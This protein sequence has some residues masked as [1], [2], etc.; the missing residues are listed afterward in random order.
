MV[1]SSPSGGAKAAEMDSSTDPKVSR[2]TAAVFVYVADTN[3]HRIQKFNAAGDWLNTWGTGSAGGGNDQFSY[4]TGIAVDSSGFIY[5]ADKSNHRIQKFNAAGDWLNTWGTGSAGGGNDQF[6][7]P[8]GIAVDSSG[9]IY[10]A[11]KSNHRIQKFDAAGGWVDT[12]GG[13]RLTGERIQETVTGSF[14]F[15]MVSRW[16]A[17][18]IF[19]WLTRI[20]TVS[21]SLA[22][23]ER[24]I[25]KWGE[26]GSHPGQMSYPFDLALS[27]SGKAYVTDSENNRVQVFHKATLGSNNKAVILA[28]G[29]PYPGNNLWNATQMCAQLCL[30]HPHLPGLYQGEHLLSDFRH[31]P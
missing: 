28:G 31:G 22:Q 6:S 12:W 19:M 24:F 11:D 21:R 20:T 15:H 29:G 9:F 1:S 13:E 23:T 16:T 8:T 4:P 7:Y 14:Y 27:T 30:P 17:V 3:N 5:V 10:V 18:I 25:T 26:P 2:W